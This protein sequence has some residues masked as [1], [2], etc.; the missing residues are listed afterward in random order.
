MSQVHGCWARGIIIMGM[1]MITT[2]RT[3]TRILTRA[4][5]D[6]TNTNTSTNIIIITITIMAMK[7][8]TATT[9]SGRRW[10]T[11]LP[12]QRSRSW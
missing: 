12:M 5:Q 10:S 6:I 8:I 4:G 1:M 9:I 11:S 7:T 2:T 3:I